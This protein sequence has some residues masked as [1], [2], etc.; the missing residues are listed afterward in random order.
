MGSYEVS[1]D[2][3]VMSVIRMVKEGRVNAV[4]LE[5]GEE[6]A[7]TIKRI[8]DAGIPVMAHIGLTP[9]RQH[10]LGRFRVQGRTASGA[11]KVLRDAMAVQE[12]RA[13]II[14]VE[15]VPAEVAAIV[16]NRLRIPTIGIG[17]G[18]GN[19]C[20]GQVLVQG[21]MTGNFPPGGFV[22]RFEKTFADVRGESV[23]GIEEYRRQVK[24]G[25]FPDGEYGYGIGE[26]ELAK[27]EDVVGGGVEGE[28][29]K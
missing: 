6:M 20:S 24:N 22:P 16:T 18:S 1:S 5:G 3:A 7:S 10:A 26:E 15:A 21:D 23:R 17:I 8:V 12:A 14:L 29:S 19:G 25:V 2:Q 28:G 13:F 11:V 27:F 9:Q 4:K